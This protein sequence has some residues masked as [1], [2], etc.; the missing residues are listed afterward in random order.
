MKRQLG[1]HRG[2]V[3]LKEG[4]RILKHWK[5]SVLGEALGSGEQGFFQDELVNVHMF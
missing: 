5:I 1:V 4:I 3:P 2:T